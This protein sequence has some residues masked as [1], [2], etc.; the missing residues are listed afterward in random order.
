MM[1]LVV[2]V[3]VV[4]E[5]LV[6]L[7]PVYK[8]V[9]LNEKFMFHDYPAIESNRVEWNSIGTVRMRNGGWGGGEGFEGRNET[10]VEHRDLLN[11]EIFVKRLCFVPIE[12]SILLICH[13]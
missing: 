5:E 8:L 6:L 3:A 11:E 12:E 2:V 1:L 13:R 10:F 4:V 7:E 9:V